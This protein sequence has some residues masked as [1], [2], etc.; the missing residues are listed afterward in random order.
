MQPQSSK[1]LKLDG[2][3][4]DALT[5]P[6]RAVKQH[7]MNELWDMLIWVANGPDG[8]PVLKFCESIYFKVLD[9]YCGSGFVMP[10]ATLNRH[11]NRKWD[12][13]KRRHAL[14]DISVTELLECLE[15][16]LFP[17]MLHNTPRGGVNVAPAIVFSIM[18]HRE[19]RGETF[20]KTAIWHGLIKGPEM[21]PKA[22]ELAYAP[23]RCDELTPIDQKFDTVGNSA[24]SSAIQPEISE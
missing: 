19:H 10:L 3:L 24:E 4:I 2:F 1:L 5:S 22:Y 11:I 15:M 9:H 17:I 6:E 20:D 16:S 18:F 23:F 13:L 14:P 8:S 12:Q 21:S 7:R